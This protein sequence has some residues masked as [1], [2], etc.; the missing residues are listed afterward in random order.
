MDSYFAARTRSVTAGVQRKEGGDPVEFD[1]CH[2]CGGPGYLLGALI[3]V[4]FVLFKTGLWLSRP[5]TRGWDRVAR[6]ADA[7]LLWAL[8]ATAASA[9]W[10][11][12]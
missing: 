4:S 11:A 9:A 1:I 2:D 7:A 5:A 3:G 10:M 6:W 12:L 8:A